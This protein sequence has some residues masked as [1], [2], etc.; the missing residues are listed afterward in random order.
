MLKDSVVYEVA[1]LPRSLDEKPLVLALR[2]KQ[3]AQRLVAALAEEEGRLDGYKIT[4]FEPP[5]FPSMREQ[6]IRRYNTVRGKCI[7]LLGRWERGELTD[8]QLVA[9][10]WAIRAIRHPEV[11]V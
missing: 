7:A 5:G 1:R 4:T 8:Q 6:K 9:A 10:M 3:S 11:A 2:S